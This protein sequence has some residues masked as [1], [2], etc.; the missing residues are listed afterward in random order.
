MLSKNKTKRC[1]YFKVLPVL[2]LPFDVKRLLGS[3][4][5]VVLLLSRVLPYF[6]SFSR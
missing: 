2:V 3:S 4:A 5:L 6:W 1:K